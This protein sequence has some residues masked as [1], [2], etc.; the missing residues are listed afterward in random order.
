MDDKIYYSNKYFDDTY[1]YRHVILSKAPEW[2][3]PQHRLLEEEEWRLLGIQQSNGWVH[4]MLHKTQPTVLF[5]RR[6]KWLSNDMYIRKRALKEEKF[7][8]EF[9]EN[10]ISN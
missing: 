4:Y 9:I 7:R 5:F 2:N 1:E 3:N 8:K 10:S 6:V